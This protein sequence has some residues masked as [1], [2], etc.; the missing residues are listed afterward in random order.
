VDSGIDLNLIGSRGRLKILRTLYEQG[1]INITRLVKLTSLNHKN[2]EKHLRYLVET[3]LVKE[4]RV[5][6]IRL[7][8]I[9]YSNPY[10][11][12]LIQLLENLRAEHY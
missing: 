12:P 7:Y 4:K 5:G 6:R 2:V 10:I 3:G 9:N 8:S 11:D 1:E